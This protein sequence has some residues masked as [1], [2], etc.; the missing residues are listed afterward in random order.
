MV[1]IIIDKMTLPRQKAEYIE[2]MMAIVLALEEKFDCENLVLP[3]LAKNL[4]N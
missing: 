3:V 4:K 1:Q 2:A